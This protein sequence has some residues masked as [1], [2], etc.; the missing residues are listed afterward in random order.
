[1]EHTSVDANKAGQK[2]AYQAMSHKHEIAASREESQVETSALAGFGKLSQEE[3]YAKLVEIGALT[4]SEAQHLK[5]GGLKDLTLAEKFI[6][7]VIGYFQVPM[8]IATNFR[9]DGR[10]VVIPLAVEETSIV[11]AASKT[12]KW[13]REV[14]EITTETLGELI[15]GQIQIARG[16]DIAGWR[17]KLQDAKPEFIKLANRDVAHGLVA[18]GGGV[19]DIV[20]REIDRPDGEKMAVIHV[21]ANPC[22]AMGANIINQV[23]EYLKGPIQELTGE[24]VMPISVTV[25]GDMEVVI[26]RDTNMIFSITAESEVTRLQGHIQGGEGLEGFPGVQIDIPALA[27]GETHMMEL[28]VP[29]KSG[30]LFFRLVG[31]FAEKTMSGA[32]EIKVVNPKEV[33]AASKRSQSS[34]MNEAP[35]KDASGMLVQPMKAAE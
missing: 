17:A 3:R 7:N 14:G 33:K 30:S 18:R 5:A 34:D 13:V 11:A 1:M 4:A 8:G 19:E 24:T 32:Y 16:R 29:A 22:D 10:D 12:A 31:D 2:N 6:E 20:L 21:H 23:C 25:E 26:S 27:A 35:T 28:N 15:I 9:I